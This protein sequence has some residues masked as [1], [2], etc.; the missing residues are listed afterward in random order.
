LNNGGVRAACHEAPPAR[1]QAPD[2]NKKAVQRTK[3]VFSLPRQLFDC[4]LAR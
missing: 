4:F 1:D 3:S 2:H